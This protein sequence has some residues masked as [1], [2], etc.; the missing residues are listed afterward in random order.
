MGNYTSA[1]ASGSGVADKPAT[2]GSRYFSNAFS[3]STPDFGVTLSPMLGVTG[4]VYRID[5]TYSSSAGNCSSNIIV[6]ITNVFGC[7]LSVTNTDK[8][9][10][11]YGAVPNS[12]STIGYLT[13]DPG[14]ANPQIT[15]YY[16]SGTVSATLQ[17]RVEMD[18]FRFVLAQPCLG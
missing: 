18:C 13:N 6:G 2:P 9:K 15:L 7:T 5:H 17:N 1:K 14:V 3:N 16:V 4:A 12:W 11:I 8:F 10:S